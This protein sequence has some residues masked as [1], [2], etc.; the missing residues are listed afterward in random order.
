MTPFHRYI[1][2]KVKVRVSYSIYFCG[3]NPNPKEMSSTPWKDTP[4]TFLRTD[5]QYGIEINDWSPRWPSPRHY[6]FPVTVSGGCSVTSSLSDWF[7]RNS[8]S[9]HWC[10][11]MNGMTTMPGLSILPWEP[12]R[13]PCFSRGSLVR[14]VHTHSTAEGNVSKTLQ[15]MGTDSVTGLTKQKQRDKWIPQGRTFNTFLS[16]WYSPSIFWTCFSSY[17][18]FAS[19]S[20]FCSLFFIMAFCSFLLSPYCLSFP[21]HQQ[22]FFCLLPSLP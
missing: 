4:N 18:F 13:S 10:L 9:C 16:F 19:P 1:H 8:I 21:S 15:A 11:G 2:N 14:G 12:C 7:Q 17:H 6:Q 22:H 20:R 3:V 5:L